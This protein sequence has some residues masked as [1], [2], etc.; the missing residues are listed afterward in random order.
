[1]VDPKGSKASIAT[2]VVG[3]H[4]KNAIN[5]AMEDLSKEDRKGIV[6]ELEEEMAERRRYKLACFQKTWHG[7]V[8]KVD[9]TT[10]SKVNSSLSPEDLVQLVDVSVASKYSADLT[11]FTRVIAEDMRN[12]LETFK[13]DLN[14]SLPRQVRAVVQQIHGESHGKWMEGSAIVPSASTAVGQGNLGTMINVSQPGPGGNPNFPQPFYQTMAYGPQMF[15]MG[16]GRSYGPVPEVLFPRTP[17][18]NTHHISTDRFQDGAMNDGVRERIATTLREFGFFPKGRARAYQKPYAYYFDTIPYPRG[19]RVLDFLK[20]T[21]DDARSTHEHIG[22]FLAQVN[23][24][25]IMDVHRVHLFPLSLSG[26]AF[27]W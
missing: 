24:V 16:S 6:K 21:G 4:A 13:Q 9:T 22:Q 27:N 17:A 23:D 25:G 14:G 7:V 1:V 3:V 12:A 11:Q 18:P 15:P 26:T 20:F 10:A 2:D 5:I 19:F 8:K